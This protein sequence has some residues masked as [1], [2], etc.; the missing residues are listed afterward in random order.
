MH[1]AAKMAVDIPASNRRRAEREDIEVSTTL[2]A[3]G[4][5]GLDVVIRNISTLGFMA[6]AANEDFMSG[7]HVRVRLPSIGTVTARIA[8]SRDGQIG[9]EFENEI[10]LQRLRAV[11]AVTGAAPAKRARG[12]RLVVT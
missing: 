5:H 1:I 6:D 4:H 12:P 7:D 2:R 11:L 3:S 8:W 10:D 9:A